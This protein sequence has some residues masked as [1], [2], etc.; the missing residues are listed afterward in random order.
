MKYFN[1]RWNNLTPDE[2]FRR[3][4]K[5]FNTRWNISTPVEIFEQPHIHQHISMHAN[6]WRL[7]M[8]RMDQWHNGFELN[9]SECEDSLVVR[10]ASLQ[11]VLDQQSPQWRSLCK[12]ETT[13]TLRIGSWCQRK[14]SHIFW[15]KMSSQGVK[16]QKMLVKNSW[17]YL[18]W[19]SVCS[20]EQAPGWV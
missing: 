2:I 20:K 8:K 10:W 15:V 19:L 14:L 4:M 1:T 16:Q 9:L 18:P 11:T 17:S 12:A 6:V 5:Y 13:R 3:Q 7:E